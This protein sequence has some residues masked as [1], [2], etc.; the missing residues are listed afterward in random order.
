MLDLIKAQAVR[1]D[2]KIVLLVADGVG[3]LPMTPGGPTELEAA[4]TPRLDALVAAN[5]C[6]AL[7]PVA[8]GITP[9]SGPGHLGLFGYDPLHYEVGRG[10]IEA[11]GIDFELG[12][13]DIAAR[14]NFCTVGPGGE[15][16][17]R[18]AGRMASEPARQL[19]TKLK[20]IR[21]AGVEVLV[22]HV[23][24]YRFVV[25]LRGDDLPADVADTDPG[26]TGVP[27]LQLTARNPGS[28][29]V[30]ELLGAFIAQAARMLADDHPANMV[31]LRG[32]ARKP[33]LPVF[34]EVCQMRAGAIAAYPMY[35]GL[36]RLV[37]MNV[38]DAGS[39][40]ADQVAS[41]A[42]HWNGYDFFFLHYKHTD[43]A[44]ED[45]DFERKV[46]C[47]EEFDAE[48]SNVMDLQ[49]DVVIVTGDHSTPALLRSHSWHPVPVLLA[50][51]TCLPDLA[52]S[53]GERQCLQGGLG[54]FQA[55]YLLP[56]ALAHAG[57]LA[58]FGA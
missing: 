46:R 50:A 34:E 20:D 5:V 28:E 54:Q 39:T 42:R 56:L 21:I 18:R 35:R 44:G 45:G 55:K 33:A 30:A 29:R 11:L 48:I 32:I 15:I 52:T 8:P 37:G 19:V 4:A 25:I 22:E 47:I 53:F 1:N 40:W 51:K 57:K 3:G 16:T 26:R 24:D 14:G 58:K 17:D 27:P 23:R 49:P 43:A 7:I 31:T 41:L 6:G 38:L 9:G 2:A 12:P 13:N 36:A 10:V